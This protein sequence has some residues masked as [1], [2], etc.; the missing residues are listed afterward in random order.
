MGLKSKS[1]FKGPH[2]MANVKF[3]FDIDVFVNRGTKVLDKGLS[4]LG[5]GLKELK[6]LTN[7]SLNFEYLKFKLLGYF[8]KKFSGGFFPPLPLHRALAL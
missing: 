4:A 7:L 1:L 8:R 3:I 5:T 6:S 2:L